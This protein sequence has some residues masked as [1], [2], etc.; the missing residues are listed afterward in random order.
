MITR[1]NPLFFWWNSLHKVT[2]FSI[3]VLI[4]IG[5][6]LSFSLSYS[7]SEQIG[8]KSLTFFI[9]HSVFA[10]ACI[11]IIL[12][13]SFGNQEGLKWISFLGFFLVIIALVI[14]LFAP[15]V[16][17][18]RRWLSFGGISLQPS[19]FLKP[20]FV[21]TFSYLF[22]YFQISTLDHNEAGK[23]LKILM[24]IIS[25]YS[26]VIFLLFLQPDFGM[27]LTF[28][29]L[30]L[31]FFYISLRSIKNFSL[32]LLFIL[33]IMCCLAFFLT[34]VQNRIK[35]FFFGL[36]NFQSKLAIKA[37]QNGG[38]LG[39]GITESQLKFTL[40]EAHN[41]FI[42]AILT[43]EFG[44]IFAATL[45]LIF[46]LIIFSNFLYLF[47]Y[48]ERIIKMF[49]KIYPFNRDSIKFSD[50]FFEK[51]IIRASREKIS[52][53]K[54]Y[55]S[56]YYD[57]IFCRNFIFG[58][59]ILLFFEF[60]LNVSVSLNLVPTKGIAMPFISYGGSSLIS[61]GIL[62]GMLLIFN[63]KRYFFLI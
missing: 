34:H 33:L 59:C 30:L 20:F 19:E 21:Y 7:V 32:G 3:L 54:N 35:V 48:K 52:N 46:L 42:F 57:F 16:K 5:S 27:I 13:F 38:F 61:H 22:T 25:L 47:D 49:V 62:I 51:V 9:K 56:V 26:T 55:R 10:F 44:F 11:L 58:A 63:R 17:G 40:P 37:I 53:A 4:A 60:F 43:E 36:E 23:K 2:F 39:K 24:C 31:S 12:F 14:T 8:V 15:D 29:T 41:D 50:E 18:A 45:G 1:D 6:I 28:T